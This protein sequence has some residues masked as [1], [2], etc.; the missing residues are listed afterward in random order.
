MRDILSF[1]PADSS[2]FNNRNGKGGG[3]GKA[4]LS[5]ERERYGI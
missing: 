1:I 3:P 2:Y 5:W 4:G